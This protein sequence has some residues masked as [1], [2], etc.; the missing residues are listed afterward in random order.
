VPVRDRCRFGVGVVSHWVLVR[1][2]LMG[3]GWRDAEEARRINV[4]F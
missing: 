4:R 1:V 2:V 3:F